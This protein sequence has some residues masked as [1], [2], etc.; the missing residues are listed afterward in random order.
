MKYKYEDMFPDEFL[1]AVKALPV[2]VIPTGLLE[3]HGDHLPL[4]LDALKACALCE[5]VMERLGGGVLLPTNYYGRPGFSSYAGTITFS[6]GCLTMLFQ[7]IF[8]QLVK[9]GAKVIVLFTGHY[10]PCQVDFIKRIADVFMTEHPEVIVLALPEYE[11]VLVDGETPAD[12]A[13]KWETS[14]MMYL[15]PEKVDMARYQRVPNPPKIYPSPPHD[16]YRESEDWSFNEDLAAKSSR[17]LGEK[18]A[19]A[20]VDMLAGKIGK[21]LDAIGFIRS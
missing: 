8:E 18:S 16:Y 5:R 3:W 2:F 11:D 19:M 7:E 21:A 1:A 15:H 12:H 6:D 10:G 4:G 13:G 20:I 9:V 14:V 17:E